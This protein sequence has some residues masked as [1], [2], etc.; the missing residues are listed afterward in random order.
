MNTVEI[1]LVGKFHLRSLFINVFNLTFFVNRFVFILDKNAPRFSLSE[2]LY[3]KHLHEKD[4]VLNVYSNGE[5]GTY[6]YLPLDTFDSS[7]K[8]ESDL[9]FQIRYG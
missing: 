8:N 2:N 7:E 5:W 1:L 9:P 3:Q 6:C 4:L